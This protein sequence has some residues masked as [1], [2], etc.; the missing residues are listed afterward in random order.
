MSYVSSLIPLKMAMSSPSR[1][2]VRDE[3]AMGGGGE[4]AVAGVIG[5]AGM[6]GRGVAVT[7]GTW[8]DGGEGMIVSR[9]PIDEHGLKPFMEEG[10]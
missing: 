8:L 7:E 1:D 3:Q 10:I 6:D 2:V 9:C 5:E 4:E